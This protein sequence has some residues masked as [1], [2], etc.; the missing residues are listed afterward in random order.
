MDCN[1]YHFYFYQIGPQIKKKWID[2]SSRSKQ[3]E[4]ERRRYTGKT[5]GGKKPKELDDLE[6]RAVAI[7]GNIAVDGVVGGIDTSVVAE[8]DGDEDVASTSSDEE[9]SVSTN[10]TKG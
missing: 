4:A 9:A 6:Q 7:L 8:E 3:K 2:F 5:G 1:I 10:N